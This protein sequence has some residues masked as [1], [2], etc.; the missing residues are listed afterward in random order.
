MIER[1]IAFK[2]RHD[3]VIDR[4]MPSDFI[5]QL[6]DEARDLANALDRALVAEPSQS[7]RLIG[8][9]VKKAEFQAA[10]TVCRTAGSQPR[11]E[12]RCGHAASP[13]FGNAA[14]K[15]SRLTAVTKE[16]DP[17]FLASSRPE[18]ISR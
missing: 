17:I 13:T 16:R 11:R 4:V 6:G 1:G 7:L 8:R 15:A 12:R 3:V 18:L 9:R 2:A 10:F 5:E 14:R